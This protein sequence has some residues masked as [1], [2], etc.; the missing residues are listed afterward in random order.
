VLKED[1]YQDVD[2]DIAPRLDG[3]PVRYTISGL[4]PGSKHQIRIRSSDSSGWR[5]WKTSLVS[6]VMQC[7]CDVPFP[8]EEVVASLHY[9]GG[10]VNEET[11][12]LK[13]SSSRGGG[14]HVSSESAIHDAPSI[15]MTWKPGDSNGS[16]IEEYE[17][18]WSSGISNHKD[19]GGENGSSSPSRGQGSFTMNGGGGGGGGG[20]SSS[21]EVV[22]GMRWRHMA[23]TRAPKYLAQEVVLGGSYSFRIRGRNANGW[24]E[25]SEVSN[26]LTVFRVL[27]PLPPEELKDDQSGEVI[28]PGVTFL[29]LCWKPP[30][31]K[32]AS[33]IDSYEMQFLDEKGTSSS[34]STNHTMASSSSSAGSTGT[35]ATMSP[36]LGTDKKVANWQPISAIGGPLTILG[37]GVESPS[38]IMQGLLP[39]H[40]YRFRIRA[41]AFEGWTDWSV[42]SEIMYTDRRF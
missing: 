36:S 38:Q 40:K 31:S 9:T 22:E 11:N 10:M 30:P 39:G 27:P 1:Q 29:R 12:K 5:P 18:S 13:S 37:A 25:Y 15:S 21:V 26:S 2:D 14:G 17:V 16:P 33:E 41:L 42:P 35:T 6:E 20:S 24:S 19:N 23:F 28:P 7:A 34:N 32:P 3:T 4:K 8:P